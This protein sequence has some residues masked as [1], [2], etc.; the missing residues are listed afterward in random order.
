MVRRITWIAI[1][2]AV[3][4]IGSKLS[5]GPGGLLVIVRIETRLAVI[6]HRI[7]VAESLW[8]SVVKEIGQGG[9]GGGLSF[10]RT[11]PPAWC[12]GLTWQWHGTGT[13]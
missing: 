2:H 4:I 1:G 10:N 8:D 12:L 9:S 5:G 13:A 3:K 7:Y 6:H 11:E